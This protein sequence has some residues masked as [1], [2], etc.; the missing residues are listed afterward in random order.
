[1]P[2]DA[3]AAAAAATAAQAVQATQAAQAAAASCESHAHCE[4]T[5]RPE[6]EPTQV[7][8]LSGAPF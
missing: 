5:P 6:A 1:M 3:A 2:L 4:K 7:E 8:H